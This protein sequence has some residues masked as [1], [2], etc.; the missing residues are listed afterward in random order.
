[1]TGNNSV[2]G[3]VGSSFFVSPVSTSYSSGAVTG[4]EK[5]GG[6]VGSS[7]SS[8]ISDSFSTGGVTGNTIVGGLIGDY[9]SG[10]ITDTFWN[11][12]SG[13]VN[14]TF[15]ASSTTGT[16]AID[17]NISYFYGNSSLPMSNWDPIIWDFYNIT[18]PHL[19]MENY[20]VASTPTPSNSVSST[21][22]PSFG[23]GAVVLAL[24]GIILFLF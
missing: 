19:A 6:L 13:N 22:L 3:L 18:L 2:G 5:V 24:L 20:V 23:F 8:S 7:E 4:N 14:Q 17:N 9:V 12:H 11:N 1:V 15:G 10:T 21:S 16:T